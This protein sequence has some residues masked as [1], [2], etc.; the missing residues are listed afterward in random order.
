MSK[1]AEIGIMWLADS[2][3][4]VADKKLFS[5]SRDFLGSVLSRIKEL[6]EISSEEELG[7][8]IVPEFEKYI[9]R[10][11]TSWMVHRI[12]SEWHDSPFWEH[13]EEPGRGHVLVWYIDFYDE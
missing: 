5:T 2:E 6:V 8:W 9:N 3:I 1:L 12:N 4:Y 13:I 11:K 7:W 10:V